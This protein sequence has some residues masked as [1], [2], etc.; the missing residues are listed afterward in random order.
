MEEKLR[1]KEKGRRKKIMYGKLYCILM[2]TNTYFNKP[3]I[4]KCHNVFTNPLSVCLCVSISILP[5]WKRLK[6]RQISY[7]KDNYNNVEQYPDSLFIFLRV[8]STNSTDRLFP[9]GDDKVLAFSQRNSYKYF[10]KSYGTKK[11]QQRR[12]NE[13]TPVMTR[14]VGKK[15]TKHCKSIYKKMFQKR[16]AIRERET[17][18]F[19]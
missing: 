15:S 18:F 5:V 17:I 9:L 13:T 1:E 7:V 12:Q 11:R 3:L 4:L 10:L 2:D 16:E 14:T 8:V 19:S 6:S